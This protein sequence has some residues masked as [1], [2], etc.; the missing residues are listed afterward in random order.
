MGSKWNK[1]Q[2]VK[3]ISVIDQHQHRKYPELEQYISKTGTVVDV[4]NVP[5]EPIASGK[6]ETPKDNYIYTVL[7][8]KREVAVPEECLTAAG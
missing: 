1:S 2:E 8:D 3:L 4:Y 7:I 6:V 5:I